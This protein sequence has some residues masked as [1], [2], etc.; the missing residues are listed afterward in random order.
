MVLCSVVSPPKDLVVCDCTVVLVEAFPL[1]AV[2]LNRAAVGSARVGVR[3]GRLVDLEMELPPLGQLDV[4]LEP[5]YLSKVLY[6][7]VARVVDGVLVVHGLVVCRLLFALK[8][9]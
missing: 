6:W 2:S 8:E 4:S 1:L 5:W 3:P 7:L 9:K